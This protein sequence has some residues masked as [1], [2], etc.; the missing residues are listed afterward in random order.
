MVSEGRVH[1]LTRKWMGGIWRVAQVPV[2]AVVH[3]GHTVQ[4][5]ACVGC[6]LISS[7]NQD[8]SDSS[9]TNGTVGLKGAKANGLTKLER[10]QFQA[11]INS[12]SRIVTSNDQVLY[13]YN[14]FQRRS[15]Q[16]SVSSKQASFARISVVFGPL[17][18]KFN[19]A[20]WSKTSAD[21]ILLQGFLNFVQLIYLTHLPCFVSFSVVFRFFFTCQCKN[22][23]LAKTTKTT[24]SM[25]RRNMCRNLQQ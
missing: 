24:F 17:R 7:C 5:K 21:F 2:T 1:K 18:M 6:L 11:S 3:S 12:S 14:R 13:E 15:Q 20:R 9:K 8:T 19:A 10:L 25:L 23:N 16:F 4:W 22:R